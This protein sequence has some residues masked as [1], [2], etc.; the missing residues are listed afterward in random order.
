MKAAPEDML[1]Q[2]TL[3]YQ[4]KIG[5]KIYVWAPLSHKTLGWKATEEYLVVIMY[6]DDRHRQK[7]Y[8]TMRQITIQYYNY[9]NNKYSH[10]TNYTTLELQNSHLM[11]HSS[12]GT[13][14]GSTINSGPKFPQLMFYVLKLKLFTQALNMHDSFPGEQNAIMSSSRNYWFKCK[15]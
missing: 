13:F 8:P 10:T 11:E 12:N 5:P 14:C 9:Q 1:H 2:N 3:E 4:L 7:G 15:I 6:F